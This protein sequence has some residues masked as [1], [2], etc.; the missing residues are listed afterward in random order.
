M[1]TTLK[2]SLLTGLALL[3][4]C[5]AP[6]LAGGS[7]APGKQKTHVQKSTDAKKSKKKASQS[8]VAKHRKHRKQHKQ[9]KHITRKQRPMRIKA[10]SAL[11]TVPMKS[12]G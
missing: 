1:N 5:S 6:A 8:T 4:L 2:R 3:T 10:P 9:H 11:K 7:E 12:S